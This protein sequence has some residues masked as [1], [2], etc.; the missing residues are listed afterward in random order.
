MPAYEQPP[1]SPV[2]VFCRRSFT[3]SL[4]LS[5]SNQVAQPSAALLRYGSGIPLAGTALGFDLV[6]RLRRFIL[7]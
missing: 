4:L 5:K 6:F 2:A 1:A 7:T 3:P